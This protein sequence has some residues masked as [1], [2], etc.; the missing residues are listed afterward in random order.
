[1]ERFPSEPQNEVFYKTSVEFD[2]YANRIGAHGEN[3]TGTLR[4]T[5]IILFRGNFSLA[6]LA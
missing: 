5:A 1:V 3:W 4:V 6:V 2:N